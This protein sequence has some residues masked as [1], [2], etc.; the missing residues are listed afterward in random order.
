MSGTDIALLIIV[1]LFAVSTLLL[2]FM[3]RNKHK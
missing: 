2:I 3:V 1:S